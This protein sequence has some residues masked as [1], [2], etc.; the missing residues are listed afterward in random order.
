MSAF[1][2][3]PDILFIVVVRY[4]FVRDVS[5]AAIRGGHVSLL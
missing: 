2:L 5:N 1:S 3:F 4:F